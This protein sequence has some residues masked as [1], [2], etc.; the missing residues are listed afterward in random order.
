MAM[1]SAVQLSGG[2]CFRIG[3]NTGFINIT[4]A[5]LRAILSSYTWQDKA[6]KVTKKP[7]SVSGEQKELFELFAQFLKMQGK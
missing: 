2:F 7:V 3:S 1:R 4:E 5:D 6:E